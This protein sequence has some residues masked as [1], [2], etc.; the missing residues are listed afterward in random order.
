MLGA[1]VMLIGLAVEAIVSPPLG[2]QRNSVF[3]EIRYSK[4]A[5][6]DKGGNRAIVLD[7]HKGGNRITVSDEAR[8]PAISLISTN[9]SAPSGGD[10]FITIHDRAGNSVWDAP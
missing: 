8:N 2:A 3:D 1:V 6:V 9:S 10:N 7:S 4:L 5:V